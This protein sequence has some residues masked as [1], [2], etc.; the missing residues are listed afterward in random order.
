MAPPLRRPCNRRARAF[1][2]AVALLVRRT[3]VHP[4]GVVMGPQPACDTPIDATITSFCTVPLGTMIESVL[5]RAGR[6]SQMVR[7]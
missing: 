3:R 7:L 6:I 2:V 4:A 1:A 5:V